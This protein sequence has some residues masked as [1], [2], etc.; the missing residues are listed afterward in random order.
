VAL[1]IAWRRLGIKARADL[2]TLSSI[3]PSSGHRDAGFAVLGRL[4]QV[5]TMLLCGGDGA[6][7][8]TEL[9]LA[10]TTNTKPSFSPDRPIG[11][12]GVPSAR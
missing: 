5:C 10:E 11:K 7:L 4:Q 1:S 2:T 6:T 12:P 8:A 3:M 9:A